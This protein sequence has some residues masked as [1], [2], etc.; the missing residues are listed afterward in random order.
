MKTSLARHLA[1]IV[2]A[3]GIVAR[4]LAA[5]AAN[6]ATGS[7]GP[8]DPPIN[9]NGTAIGTGTVVDDVFVLDVLPGD[10][11]NK[12]V[13][14]RVSWTSPSND[15]DLGIAKQSDGAPA[16]SSGSGFPTTEEIASINPSALGTGKYEI[17]VN[18]FANTPGVDQPHGE[19]SVVDI[20]PPRA[21][22]YVHGGITFAPNTPVKAS[23]SAQDGEPSSRL[24]VFGNYYIGGIRGV[25]AGVDLWYF[26]LRPTL[27]ATGTAAITSKRTGFKKDRKTGLSSPSAPSAVTAAN[28]NYDPLMRVPIYRGQPDSATANPLAPFDAAQGGFGGGDI[29]LAVGFG[30]YT[31]PD[32][33]LGDPFPSL[34][35]S[36]LLAAS[37]T[38]GRSLDRGATFQ[39]NPVGN[40]G[41]GIPVNDRQW[42]EFKG[43]NQVYL[44]YRKFENSLVFIQRS[45]NGGLNYGAAVP[46]GALQQTGTVDVDQ[47][48][49]NVYI[50]SSDGKVATGKPSANTLPFTV[51]D[52]PQVYTTV[53][54]V[55]EAVNHNNLFFAMKVADGPR[56]GSG[57]LTG[58]G[59]VYVAYSDGSDIYLAHSSDQGATWS[60]R[61][62]VNDPAF[63]D[64]NVNVFPWLET[65][66][67]PGTVGVCWYASST[68]T[69]NNSSN[70]KVF[71][72]ITYDA[73]SNTPTFQIAQ[74]SDHFIHGSNI[75]M[76]GLLGDANRNLIDY[77]QIT[78]DPLGAAVIGYTD[79][80]NDFAGHTYVARQIS[81][82][83]ILGS[84]ITVPAPAEGS[85]LPANPFP[86]PGTTAPPGGRIPQP[87]Q[88]GP[89]GEQVTDFAQDQD[90]GLVAVTP[91][92]SPFD[93]ISIKYE[94]QDS[95]SGPVITATMKVSDLSTIPNDGAW[96]MYFTA[97]APDTGI[98]GPTGNQYSRGLS[99]RGDQF[100]V[101]VAT[102]EDGTR[103]TTWGTVVRDSDGGLTRTQRG[104]ADRS[105]V[106]QQDKTISVRISASKLN[107]Y[108]A[109]LAGSHPP[110]A[111]GTVLC[112]LRGEAEEAIVGGVHDATRGGTELALTNPF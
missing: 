81:G 47:F 8:N 90:V 19:I 39:F 106:N 61:V 94:W 37:V 24:D 33:V 78:F 85:G 66:P 109:G 84:G 65:G 89:N 63:A 48:N 13:K 88:P 62:T 104:T 87:M 54:A 26:D 98:I 95:N 14:V 96:R 43:N 10:W 30:N 71:Y 15:Y 40:A 55:N 107:S 41:G 69:N 27:P 11:T 64:T 32:A 6:P 29:D 93:I 20:G 77:F 52:P 112:G 31:G 51:N 91:A 92:N 38:Y 80:H 17:V 73:T 28:P 82:P 103:T 22:N 70:W 56:D 68:Q 102:A 45:E 111:L 108:L 74:V 50:S 16:G 36:S 46:V 23:T 5:D 1:V 25:P 18:Y 99:D 44:E 21:A 2:S 100:Y 57:N 97:N 53:Q 58:P 101:Q 72:A 86:A 4:P 105:F 83:S 3:I 7:I 35:Y 110:I 67:V 59:I 79:D 34:A 9:Y 12:L 76:G 60:T 75:S 42:M 49:G